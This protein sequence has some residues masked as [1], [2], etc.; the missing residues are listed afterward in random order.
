MIYT[1][2]KRPI[3]GKRKQFIA[4]WAKT[5]QVGQ[6]TVDLF[7]E[8]LLFKEGATEH[9]LPVQKQVIPFFAR[10]LN[11]GA[12]VELYL[13]WIGARTEDGAT[14]WVFLVN[15]FNRGGAL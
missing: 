2:E 5:R 7:E 11:K 6:E 14:D 9:W 12:A 8:E 1:G 4:D 10:E 15:E 13:M 3:P